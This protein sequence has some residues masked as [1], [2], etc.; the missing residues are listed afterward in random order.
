M[1]DLLVTDIARTP[2]Q[3][4]ARGRPAGEQRSTG[5]AQTRALPAG[6]DL[7]AVVAEVLEAIAPRSGVLEFQVDQGQTVVR[8]V[9]RE[10]NQLIRQIPTVEL[11]ELRRALE[12]AAGALIRSKA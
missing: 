9:D 12:Q 10:T 5:P 1:K 7:K 2:E 3:A 4:P 6:Q 8:V 11:L